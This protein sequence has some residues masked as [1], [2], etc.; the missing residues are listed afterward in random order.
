[1]YDA[2]HRKLTGLLRPSVLT[3]TNESHKHAGHSGNPSGAADAAD[4]E[5]HFNV[6]VV[7][8][9]FDGLPAVARHRLIYQ[10]LQE[11]LAA[12][13]HALS[14]TTKTPSEHGRA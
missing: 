5:T 14:L 13:L 2:I 3:I 4:A 6:V 7:S 8:D 10:A 1:V 9:A 12:G 11:E